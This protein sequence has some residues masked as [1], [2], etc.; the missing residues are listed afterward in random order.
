MNINNHLFVS[1]C[2]IHGVKLLNGYDMNV[3][4]CGHTVNPFCCSRGP[5]HSFQYGE[6][7]DRLTAMFDFQP[8]SQNIPHNICIAGDWGNGPCPN[9]IVLICFAYL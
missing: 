3:C 5:P 7:V 6:I 9:Q 2:R 1:Y 4:F 8:D